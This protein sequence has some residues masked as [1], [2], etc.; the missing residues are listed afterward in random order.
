MEKILKRGQIA[1]DKKRLIDHCQTLRNIISA[2]DKVM[3]EPESHERG[4]KI[5]QIIN[6]IEYTLDVIEHFD[7]KKPFKKFTNKSEY[8]KG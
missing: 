5:A 1:V 2:A 6:G 8:G 3:K 4:K 7:L